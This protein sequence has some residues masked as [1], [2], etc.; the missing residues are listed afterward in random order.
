[1]PKTIPTDKARQGRRGRNV[2]LIL[3]GG[4]LLAFIVWAL[5]EIY[6]R[7]IEPPQGRTSAMIEPP[8][9]LLLT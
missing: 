7:T 3:L 2:L 6:G 5:V 4:L 1:M 8:P 9:T